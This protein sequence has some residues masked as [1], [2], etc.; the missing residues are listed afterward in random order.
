MMNFVLNFHIL[1]ILK[2]IFMHFNN[3]TIFKFRDFDDFFQD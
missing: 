2:I 1:D 3:K